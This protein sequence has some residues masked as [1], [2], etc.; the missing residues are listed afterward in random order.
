MGFI[1]KVNLLYS[2]NMKTMPRYQIKRLNYE[3]YF[4]F[5]PFLLPSSLF[6]TLQVELG[7]YI[8]REFF[9]L[10]TFKA[11]TSTYTFAS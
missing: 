1:R 10:F 7:L 4:S 5:H 2:K 9:P 6:L 3:L 8:R 11:N